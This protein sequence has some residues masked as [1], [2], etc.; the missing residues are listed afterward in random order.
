MHFR[1]FRVIANIALVA[2]WAVW[3]GNR[4]WSAFGDILG[5]CKACFGGARLGRLERFGCAFR[6][7]RGNSV[8]C[9]DCAGF[10]LDRLGCISGRLDRFESQ[11]AVRRWR[12]KP[13]GAVW[14]AF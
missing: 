11:Q 10:G 8:R 14:R 3:D 5:L 1:T 12:F 13:F 2:V 4:V 7:Q 6:E 9:E